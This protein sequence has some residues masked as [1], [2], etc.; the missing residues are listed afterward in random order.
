V[1]GES[2]P[3]IQ[4][5]A[6]KGGSHPKQPLQNDGF[7][8]LKRDER[9]PMSGRGKKKKSRFMVRGRTA[10]ALAFGKRGALEGEES[11]F[12]FKEK[13]KNMDYFPEKDVNVNSRREEGGGGT[14][15]GLAEGLLL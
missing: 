9:G 11:T 10:G 15:P 4:T 6:E 2:P 13:K 8:L 5:P 3:L 7:I 14:I 1:R 12:L